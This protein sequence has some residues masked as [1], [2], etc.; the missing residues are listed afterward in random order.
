LKESGNPVVNDTTH[1]VDVRVR[2][3][4]ASE[5]LGSWLATHTLQN[6]QA[7]PPTLPPIG[8]D[9]GIGILPGAG[10]LGPT[11]TP[12]TTPSGADVKPFRF[13]LIDALFKQCN[14]TGVTTTQD[15]G[16]QMFDDGTHSDVTANDGI[17]TL[18]F[19]NTQFEGSYIFQFTGSGAAPSGSQFSRGKTMADYVR[20]EV[21]AGSSPFDSRLVSQN[22]MFI[23][24]EYHI[25]PRDRFGNYLG[26]GYPEQVRFAAS[27]GQ[28]LGPV[29]DYGNGYYARVLRYDAGQPPPVVVPTVQEKPMVP[30]GDGS[31]RPVVISLHAGAAMPHGTLGD[32]FDSGVSVGADL[33]YRFTPKFS[34]EAFAGHDRFGLKRVGGSDFHVTHLSGHGKLTLPAGPI[35]ASFHAGVG[36]YFLRGGTSHFGWN[37]GVGVH[38]WL[39]SRFAVESTYNYRQVNVSGPDF[40]YSTL[41]GGIR[42]A[43]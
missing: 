24:R 19:T 41:H 1:P 6:C 23:V 29:T 35:H 15:P 17:Y 33:E 21:D 28:W 27:S 11:G 22:A 8:R 7:Q 16:L 39:N 37:V 20:V 12:A 31:M 38:R 4:R 18:R 36:A 10:L 32:T 30:E 34:V 42:I 13:A 25:L 14:K 40:K 9:V 3:E 26:P 5:S 2:I 43:F